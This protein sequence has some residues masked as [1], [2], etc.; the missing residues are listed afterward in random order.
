MPDNGHVSWCQ[1]TDKWYQKFYQ[2]RADRITITYHY[3]SKFKS[4][5]QVIELKSP[6]A[7]R[8]CGLRLI[9]KDLR[10]IKTYLKEYKNYLNAGNEISTPNN[11]SFDSL[12]AKALLTTIVVHYN[13]CFP[14]TKGRHA[15]LQEKEISRHN[16]ETH[17]LLK[18]LRNTYIAHSDSTRYEGCSYVI[19]IPPKNKLYKNDTHTISLAELYQAVGMEGLTDEIEQLIQELYEKVN[20]KLRVC[21][22]TFNAL[23]SKLSPE[24]VYNFLK[25]KG[26]RVTASLSQFEKLITE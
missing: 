26:K 23:V 5:S 4:S 3:D 16:I 22:E 20:S 21:E 25:G 10:D 7:K 18:K 14:G 6:Q 12:I 9:E 2:G 13:R 17:R 11:T 19:L 15:L 8:Y 24:K 1:L